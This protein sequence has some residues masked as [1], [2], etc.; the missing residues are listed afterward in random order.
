[1]EVI[2]KL[3]QRV[4]DKQQKDAVAHS[5]GEAASQYDQYA[6]IQHRIANQLIDLCPKQDK[7]NILDLGCGTGYCLPLLNKKYPKAKIIGGDLSQ[8]MLDYAKDHYPKSK[9]EN[10]NYSICDAEKLPF[11]DDQFDFIF[12]NF[13]VQ[14]CDDFNTVLSEAYR[15]LQPGGQLLLSTLAQGTLKELKQAWASADQY[16][17]VN[18][19]IDGS[20]LSVDARNSDFDVQELLLA[21]EF[22]YYDSVR[23]LTDSLKRIGAHNITPG[24]AKALTSPGTIKKFTKA[25][26]DFKIEQGIPARYKV[27]ICLLKKPI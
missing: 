11:N 26:M 20:Q 15:C 1:L 7:I 23:E 16:Q 10:F 24:R 9:S 2:T 22:E 8:G 17:H 6:K 5:F 12:S 21:T 27:F 14:W 25:L 13:A 18:E 3:D 4:I 19:F